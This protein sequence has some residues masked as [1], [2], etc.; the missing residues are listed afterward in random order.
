MGVTQGW[1]DNHRLGVQMSREDRGRPELL[2]AFGGGWA[3]MQ[4][5]PRATTRCQL[6]HEGQRVARRLPQILSVLVDANY[7]G[8]VLQRRTGALTHQN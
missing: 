6:L 5:Y 7:V 8:R 3:Q 2:P 4:M 1:P